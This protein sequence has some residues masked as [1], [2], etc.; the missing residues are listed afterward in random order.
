MR[1]F[2]VIVGSQTFSTAGTFTYTVPK[3]F[4]QIAATVTPGSPGAPGAPGNPCFN[5]GP[6][7]ATCGFAGSPGSPSSFRGAGT[8]TYLRGGATY[9]QPRSGITVVVGAGG[10]GGPGGNGGPYSSPGAPGSPGPAGSVVVN[11]S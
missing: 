10:A 7:S 9:I 11:V 5:C 4:R 1:G 6:N 2:A 3:G 8:A